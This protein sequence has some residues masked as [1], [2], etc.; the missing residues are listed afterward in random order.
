MTKER[1][2]RNRNIFNVSNNLVDQFAKRCVRRSN[3][4]EEQERV[5]FDAGEFTKHL[6]YGIKLRVVDAYFPED[7]GFRF[8][9]VAWVPIVESVMER[10]YYDRQPR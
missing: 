7:Y 6:M 5:D 8:I 2:V 10:N 3:F 1:R 9:F 4:K